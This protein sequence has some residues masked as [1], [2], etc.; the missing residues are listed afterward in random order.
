MMRIN[1]KAFTL[2][3]LLVVVLI[4]GIL[5]A[6]ALPQ[7]QKAVQKSRAASLIYSVKAAK[8]LIDDYYM[9]R[10]V[11]PEI[12]VLAE[13]LGLVDTLDSGCRKFYGSGVYEGKAF[14]GKYFLSF[15]EAGNPLQYAFSLTCNPPSN[16]YSIEIMGTTDGLN[17]C[18]KAPSRKP[19]CLLCRTNTDSEMAQYVCSFFGKDPYVLHQNTI[20]TIE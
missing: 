17:R 8:V 5:A 7:Y 19:S 3:E 15:W 20:Y 11:Y 1:K 16:S 13:E 9:V 12:G 14:G 4:I 6:I 10:G 18:R 2:I